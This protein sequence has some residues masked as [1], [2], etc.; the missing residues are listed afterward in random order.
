MFFFFFFVS[1]SCQPKSKENSILDQK[2]TLSIKK[3]EGRERGWLVGA[4]GPLKVS[5]KK[6]LR[7]TYPLHFSFL[8]FLK[9]KKINL[10]FFSSR[11]F[12]FQT[13]W[14]MA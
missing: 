11:R 2:E 1:A 10:N 5:R 14:R 7:E 3:S 12:L 4:R 9:R 8:F 13:K 6:G